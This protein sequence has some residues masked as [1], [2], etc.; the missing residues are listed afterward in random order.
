MR[1]DLRVQAYSGFTTALQ[2]LP[3]TSQLSAGVR[4]SRAL[5]VFQM[6]TRSPDLVSAAIADV[7]ES[8]GKAEGYRIWPHD[9][10]PLYALGDFLL[11][12]GD[13]KAAGTNLEA[14]A[15][16]ALRDI[17]ATVDDGLLHAKVA[18]YVGIF[19]RLAELY[20]L[21]RQPWKALAAVETLRAATIRFHTM[22]AAGTEERERQA[23]RSAIMHIL[24]MDDQQMSSALPKLRLP[25]VRKPIRSLF[26]TMND[27]DLA[28]VA[29]TINHGTVTAIIQPRGIWRFSWP[30]IAR[31]TIDDVEKFQESAINYRT[32]HC[33]KSGFRETWVR[34]R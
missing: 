5:V 10:M 1:G 23:T 8:L 26:H 9:H 22:S 3:A 28:L 16:L 7:K 20:S 29:L 17:N 32:G 4:A 24:Q 21:R 14:A 33:A 18:E 2:L 27:D 11:T 13:L 31:W 19:E 25:D 6:S 34:G 15:S 30:T 12:Q